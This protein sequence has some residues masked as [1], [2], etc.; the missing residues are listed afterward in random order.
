MS[1]KSLT[2]FIRTAL[3]AVAVVAAAGTAHAGLSFQ[4]T[5]MGTRTEM[6]NNISGMTNLAVGTTLSLGSLIT[7]QLGTV[8][9]TYLGQESG[10]SDRLLTIGGSTLLTESNAVGTTVSRAVTAPGAIDF[11][12]EGYNGFYAINGGTWS[13]GTSIGLLGQNRTVNGT[14][15][16]FVLGYNDS[17]GSATLGDWDDFVVGVNFKASPVTAVPEPETYGMMLVG[18][19]LIGTIARRRRKS[20]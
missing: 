6:F 5:A 10:Y 8:S 3:A 11:Q 9:F 17:A 16:D 1:S 15:F 12:F 20:A 19:G 7:D 18:L 13:N 2:R 14:L 4:Q